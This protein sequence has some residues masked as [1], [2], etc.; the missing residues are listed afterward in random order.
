MG[1][2]SSSHSLQIPFSIVWP[3]SLLQQCRLPSHIFNMA[4]IFW[5]TLLQFLKLKYQHLL[6]QCRTILEHHHPWRRPCCD[7]WKLGKNFQY[8]V[9]ALCY[10]NHLI[11]IFFFSFLN[12]QVSPMVRGSRPPYSDNLGLCCCGWRELT[13]VRKAMEGRWQNTSKYHFN[14][15]VWDYQ[16]QL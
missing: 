12:W 9:S 14:F 8:V 7:C 3:K 15:V 11:R 10:V 5:Q 16:W 13:P 1:P 6:I 4:T 2:S